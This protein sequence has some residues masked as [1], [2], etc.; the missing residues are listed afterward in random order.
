M[1]ILSV[2]FTIINVITYVLYHPLRLNIV[3]LYMLTLSECYS[4]GQAV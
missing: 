1:N 2:F 3:C 4:C